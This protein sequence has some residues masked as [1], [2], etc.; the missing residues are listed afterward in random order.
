MQQLTT[1][2]NVATAQNTIRFVLDARLSTVWLCFSAFHSGHVVEAR[3]N[4]LVTQRARLARC[5]V[6]FWRKVKRQPRDSEIRSLHIT[7][8]LSTQPY[9]VH[10]LLIVPVRHKPSNLAMLQA[11]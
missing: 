1:G 9:T 11:V 2:C 6:L 7:T 3:S 4:A 8:S 5:W 10:F